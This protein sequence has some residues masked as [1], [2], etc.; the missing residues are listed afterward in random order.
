VTCIT[1]EPASLTQH[2]KRFTARTGNTT[3]TKRRFPGTA[4]SSPEDT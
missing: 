3:V 4:L 1:Q 2:G